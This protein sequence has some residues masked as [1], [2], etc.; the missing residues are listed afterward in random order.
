[1]FGP[2][3]VELLPVCPG[4]DAGP[5]ELVG[6]QEPEPGGEGLGGQQQQAPH[7]QAVQHNK[8]PNVGPHNLHNTTLHS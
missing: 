2:L 7:R 1:M 3:L 6:C 5:G 4:G 8:L